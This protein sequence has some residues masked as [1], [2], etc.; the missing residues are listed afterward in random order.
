MTIKLGALFPYT[1]TRGAASALTSAIDI[2][3]WDI[4]GQSLG[5]PIYA[6]LGGPVRETIPLY[7][8][9]GC[10]E[11]SEEAVESARLQV[12][13]GAQAIKTDPFWHEMRHKGTAITDG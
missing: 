1:G 9:Y 12:R 8:H 2:A 10:A 13:E 4:R 6:L 3:L 5:V 7:T 11:T